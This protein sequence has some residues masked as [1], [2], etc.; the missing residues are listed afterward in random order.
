MDDLD[1]VEHRLTKALPTLPPRLRRA[2]VY[3]LENPGDIATL[4]MRKVAAEADLALPHFDRLAKSIG[5]K[6]YNELRDVYRKH[7]Q[8]GGPVAYPERVKKLQ[9]SGKALGAEAIWQTFKDAAEQSVKVVF[10]RIDAELISTTANELQ[11]RRHIYLVGMQASR[12]FMTYLHYIGGMASAKMRPVGR[13]GSVLAD[14]VVDL[15]TDDAIICIALRPYAAATVRVAKLA[16]QRGA[17]VVAI[18]DSR[19]SPLATLSDRVL[20]APVMSP[21]FFDSYIG[22]TAIIEMLIGFFAIGSGA[23]T[24][25][26]VERIEADRNDLGEYWNDEAGI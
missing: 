3:V 9:S 13:N 18:T 1:T 8:N 2:A 26:R 7:V 22:T 10:D 16:R 11:K 14:D 19:A 24:V 5:F 17:F 15:S 20:L 23:A 4:S 21:S 6:T 25:E 12:T